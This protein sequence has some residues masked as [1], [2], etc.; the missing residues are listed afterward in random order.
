MQVRKLLKDGRA[1]VIEAKSG[2]TIELSKQLIKGGRREIKGK[3][4]NPYFLFH[5]LRLCCFQTV[6]SWW[7][8]SAEECFD[9][10]DWTQGCQARLI[11]LP[12]EWTS[13]SVYKKMPSGSLKPKWGLHFEPTINE[14]G[15]PFLL[16]TCM[17]YTWFG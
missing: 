7:R 2:L 11:G 17:G 16:L 12:N 9:F 14:L 13:G 5:K 8:S 6:N 10:W 1:L 15:L 3:A 4:L